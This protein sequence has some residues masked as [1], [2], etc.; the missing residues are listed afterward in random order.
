M[1]GSHLLKHWSVTQ[2]TIALSSGE[3]ELVGIVKGAAEGLGL[4]A[5][6]RDLGLDASLKLLAD[7]SVA[8]GIC[9]RTGIGRVRHL[10]TGQRWVQERVRSGDF[11]LCKHPGAENPADILTKPVHG[12]LLDRHMASLGLQWEAGRA[13]SAPALDGFSWGSAQLPAP[14]RRQG[15]PRPVPSADPHC[16]GLRPGSGAAQRAGTGGR[17]PELEA[18]GAAQG[19][20]LFCLALHAPP[21][22]HG[23]LQ[24][25]SSC[26][27]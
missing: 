19:G 14:A 13:A 17:G 16:R 24:A 8:I 10:A 4:V 22:A 7:S 6:A 20:E 18:G 1:R 27:P 9:R 12:D 2:K 11:E 25:R 5:V 15:Q 21:G 3:A 26:P 23:A